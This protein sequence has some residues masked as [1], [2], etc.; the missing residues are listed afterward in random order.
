MTVYEKN[1]KRACE[2]AGSMIFATEHM[3]PPKTKK[4]QAETAI[5]NDAILAITKILLN[6]DNLTKDDLI[7]IG[8]NHKDF[9]S[10]TNSSYYIACYTGGGGCEYTRI[11][12]DSKN[13][14]KPFESIEA[15]QAYIDSGELDE[16]VYT[17]SHIIYTKII[18]AKEKEDNAPDYRNLWLPVNKYPRGPWESNKV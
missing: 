3:L 14:Y 11:F 9:N 12:E 7:D 5:K 4:A 10:Y 16:Y 18:T 1:I 15:A 2:Y 6:N 13:G 17:P 8:V